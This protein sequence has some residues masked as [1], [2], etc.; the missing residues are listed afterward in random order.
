MMRR[1]LAA[2][3][4]EWL[5]EAESKDECSSRELSDFLAYRDRD[6]RYADFHSTRHIFV[7]NLAKAHVHP[8]FCQK[9]ARHSDPRLTANIYTHLDLDDRAASINCLNSPPNARPHTPGS[10]SQKTNGE[11]RQ[12]TLVAPP[13]A[14]PQVRSCR[15]EPPIDADSA[16]KPTE[17]EPPNPFEH[18]GFDVESRDLSPP[19]EVRPEGFEPP[20]LGSEDRCSIQLS[21]GRKLLYTNTLQRCSDLQSDSG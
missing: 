18:K 5:A 7:T 17:Q 13:V 12:K 9:L 16:V 10:E 21:Y 11:V 20:T 4:K 8:S 14:V 2:A 3:R 19:V 6:G 15:Q 1:D